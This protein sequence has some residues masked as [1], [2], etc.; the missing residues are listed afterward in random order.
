MR[1]AWLL[2]ACALVLLTAKAGA[3][4][5]SLEY[6]AD[7]MTSVFAEGGQRA[8]LVG[9][10][11]VQT[12][13]T[14]IQADRMQLFGKDFVYVTCSGNVKVVNTKRGM[15]VTSDSLFYDRDQ[16]IARITGNAVMQDFKNEMVVKGGFI[17]DRDSEQI[18]IIQIGVRILKKDLV[19]RAEFAR[20]NRST[21]ILE[22]SGMP[23]V[24]RKGDEYAAARISVN[25]DT[26]EITLEGDVKGQIATGGEKSSQSPAAGSETPTTDGTGAQQTAPAGSPA[27]TGTQPAAPTAAPATPTGTPAAP[28]GTAPAA[29]ALGATP[30]PSATPAP[31]TTPGGNSGG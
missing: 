22:L 3:A 6:F 20:F 14:L 31:A 4:T 12:E 9:H 19:C 5:K 7:T 16:K 10:A 29:P 1:R 27:G 25:T 18:T 2:A 15:E 13:D 23:W 28:G 8:E 21:N 26:E 30:A 17:E 24:S 11:R